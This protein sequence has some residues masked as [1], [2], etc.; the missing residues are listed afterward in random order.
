MGRSKS[1]RSP[2]LWMA[3]GF[4]EGR[5]LVGDFAIEGFFFFSHEAEGRFQ[6]KHLPYLT[7]NPTE[8]S[9]KLRTSWNYIFLILAFECDVAVS[10]MHIY[11]FR[12]TLFFV[13]NIEPWGVLKNFKSCKDMILFA[14]RFRRIFSCEIAAAIAKPR[15]GAF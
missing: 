2:S 13:V 5:Q 15:K 14:D 7:S 6:S 12:G 11:F 4:N 3:Q 8:I 9:G 1:Q 10:T